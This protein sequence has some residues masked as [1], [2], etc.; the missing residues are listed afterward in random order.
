LLIEQWQ[1]HLHIYT[2]TKRVA[3]TSLLGSNSRIAR[4]GG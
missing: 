2:M 4:L 3:N 1:Q